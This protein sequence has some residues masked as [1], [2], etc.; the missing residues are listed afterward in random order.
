MFQEE[1]RIPRGKKN[2]EVKKQR[3]A[4]ADIFELVFNMDFHPSVLK[5]LKNYIIKVIGI[6]LLLL[7]SSVLEKR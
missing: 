5:T 3:L 7:I 6:L 1:R 4:L 2:K